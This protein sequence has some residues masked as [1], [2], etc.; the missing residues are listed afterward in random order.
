VAAEDEAD[1]LLAAA[2]EGGPDRDATLEDLV[3][4]RE[5]GEPLAWVV[6]HVTFC[7]LR[8]RVDPGV[9]VPRPHTEW[10]AV[11]AAS[12]LPGDGIAVDLCT[13]SGAVAAVARAAHPGATVLATDVDPAAIACA[14]ANDV[15]ALLGDL[16]APLPRALAGRVDVISAVVPYVPS[17]EL[18][19][20]PRDV[21]EHEPRDALDGGPRGTAV[22]ERAA[23]AAAGWLRP[24][25]TVLLEIGGRQAEALGAVFDEAGLVDADVHHDEDGLVRAIEARLRSM[26]AR[27]ASTART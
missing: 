2:E 15:D 1:L 4:R 13:G 7:G 25:G 26:N 24:G 20:L 14:R 9:F 18:R 12:L 17:E 8:V 16:D 22:L 10:L 27:R 3:S 11:R 5:R 23:R 19:L 6:G 21:L